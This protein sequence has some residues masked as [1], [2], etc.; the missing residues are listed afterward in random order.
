MRAV[1][2][3]CAVF[4]FA[5]C[6]TLAEEPA[7]AQVRGALA[8]IGKLRVGL[9]LGNPLSAIREGGQTRGV[10]HEL[11]GELARLL[12]VPFEPV[13]YPSVGALLDGAKSGQW[14]AAFFLVTPERM[15]AFDFSPPL[16]ELELGYLVPQG[17]PIAAV[18]D[19]DRPGRR[20]AVAEKGQGDVLLSRTLKNAAL[21]RAPGL[22]AV[23]DRLRS[24]QADAIASNKAI[25]IELSGQLPGARILEGSFA[26][27]SFALAI[28]KGRDHGLAFVRSFVEHAKS[29]GLA[30]GAMDRSGARGAVI[31]SGHAR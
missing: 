11:G 19:V 31:A 23:V 3:L 9:Y 22:A 1:I 28:P 17:S 26:T 2:L 16:L 8:P 21:V 24:G 10:G 5:G 14:D 13:I 29:S 15:R 27:E 7:S 30:K 12:G 20:I 6:A 18:H 4:A 25:L